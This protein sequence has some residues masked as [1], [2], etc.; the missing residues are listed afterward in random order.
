MNRCDSLTL[1]SFQASEDLPS[2]PLVLDFAQSDSPRSSPTPADCSPSDSPACPTSETCESET[3]LPGLLDSSESSA[4]AILASLR[5]LPG[6]DEARLMTAGSG[7]Q[8]AGLSR[9]CGPLGSL[10][11]M[12]LGTSAWG[13]MA[14]W[15]TWKASVTPR[16]RLLFQLAPSMPNIAETECGLLPTPTAACA[17][18]GQTSRS[19][20]RKGEI[21]LTGYAR[22]LPTPTATPY[23]SNQSLSPGAAVRPSLNSLVKLWPT[24]CASE[25]RQGLQIRREGKKGSQQ[26]LTTAVKL[27]PTPAAQDSK[28]ATLPVSL[29]DRDT[30]PGAMLRNGESGSL[31]PQW[32]EWLMGY[33]IGHTALKDS[34]TLLSRRSPKTSSA[35][36]RKSKTRKGLNFEFA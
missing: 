21:L 9:L 25:A 15:L 18:G 30:V 14:C 17:S 32:V 31:N 2:P 22:M 12:C 6:S 10:V 23:G 27:W 1:T 34:G 5:P 19:G 13:S 36:L 16:N 3:T 7:R 4:P 8:L 24:P 28:N 11:R 20:A 33:P 26:S 29:R 35:G